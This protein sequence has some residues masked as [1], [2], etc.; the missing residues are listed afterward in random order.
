MDSETP[1]DLVAVEL[2]PRPVLH[3]A[4]GDQAERG[5]FYFGQ[6]ITCPL[7]LE[8]APEHI[9]A[10]AAE[11]QSQVEFRQLVMH[12]SLSPKPGEPIRNVLMTVKTV[13]ADCTGDLLLR[14][15][16]PQRLTKAVTRHSALTVKADFGVLNPEASHGSQYE[17]EDPF[18]VACGI[19][20]TSVQWE[21]RK[22]TGQD[23]DGS[24][25]LK[26]TVELP[27]GVTGSFRL[28]ASVSIRRKRLGVIGYDALLPEDRSV[29]PCR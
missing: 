24:H 14:D 25:Q 29:V 10:Y 15:A 3:G 26:A 4:Q 6:P 16:S 2:V 28:S 7:D 9:R 27:V 12:L 22:T 8:T 1:H 11:R 13:P 19:D 23:L 20:T 17:R 5:V 18:L 21:F